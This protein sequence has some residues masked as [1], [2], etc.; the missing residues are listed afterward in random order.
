MWRSKSG[1]RNPYRSP[2]RKPPQTLGFPVRRTSFSNKR[3]RTRIFSKLN[4]CGRLWARRSL[5]QVHGQIAKKNEP[6]KVEK[7]ACRLSSQEVNEQRCCLREK[8][9]WVY[10]GCLDFHPDRISSLLTNCSLR[11][12]TGKHP[13]FLRFHRQQVSQSRDDWNAELR[14]KGTMSSCFSDSRNTL[15]IWWWCWHSIS[16]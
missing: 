6:K 4:E 1:K 14:Q 12:F 7:F 8:V 16:Q 10:I 15:V 3:T 11:R 2:L 5:S 9:Y 13:K